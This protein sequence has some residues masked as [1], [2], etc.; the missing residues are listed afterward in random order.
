V[1]WVKICGTTSLEDALVAV[2]AGADAVGF[3]FYDKSPRF[4]TAERARGIVKELPGRVETVGVFLNEEP[5]RLAELAELAGVSA[6]Q[7]HGSRGAW[8]VTE[9][10]MF[11]AVPA[12]ELMASLGNLPSNVSAVF[13]DSSNGTGGAFD[14]DEAGTGVRAMMRYFPVVVAG[15]LTPENV[16]GM[17]AVLEPWGVDVVSGVER[18][19]GRKDAEKVK[20]FVAAVRGAEREREREP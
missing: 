20:A 8:P 15:G 17:M 11:V 7:V 14:W 3:V 19:P 6:V 5:E 1:T 9:K 16:A 12:G 4:V 2:E 10:K 18:E 13:A